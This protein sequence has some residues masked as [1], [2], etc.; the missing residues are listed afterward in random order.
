MKK[1]R[2]RKSRDT[3]PLTHGNWGNWYVLPFKTELYMKIRLFHLALSTWRNLVRSL[4]YAYINAYINDCGASKFMY[5]H[6]LETVGL[7]IFLTFFLLYDN[8][9]QKNASNAIFYHGSSR[10]CHGET[11]DI[12]NIHRQNQVIA[13]GGGRAM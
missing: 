12:I 1:T 2:S 11:L 5:I 6:L 7:Q 13:D 9:P 8:R 4:D 3:V 10:I